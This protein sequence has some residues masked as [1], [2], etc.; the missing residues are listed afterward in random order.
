MVITTF[1]LFTT[2]TVRVLGRFTSIPDCRMGAV[3]M[4]MTS[5]TSITS[6]KGVTLISESEVCVVP[7]GL[8][9]AIGKQAFFRQQEQFHL[10]G[11]LCEISLRHIQKLKGTFIQHA[12]K[13]FYAVKVMIVSNHGGD[14]GKEAGRSG[15]EG[16]RDTGRNALQ[17]SGAGRA[18]AIKSINNPPYRSKEANKRAYGA[19]GRQPA[20]PVL[21]A[22]ELFRRGDLQGATH[23][24]QTANPRLSGILAIGR[25]SLNLP[26][27]PHENSGQGASSQPLSRGANLR[28]LFALVKNP[29]E[30]LGLSIGV[31]ESAILFKNDGPGKNRKEEKN[32][33]DDSCDDASGRKKL[34]DLTL[35]P[36]KQG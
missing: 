20:Q 31:F 2:L 24:F 16:F 10:S 1:S 35:R 18:Q 22:R 28:K 8:V 36:E 26:I 5:S 27:S 12:P 4:K 33:Q 29:D 30:L 7:L 14:G 11:R 32:Q 23:R 34:C 15:D 17:R 3:S 19:R 6:T 9:K 13:F 21:H 25:L